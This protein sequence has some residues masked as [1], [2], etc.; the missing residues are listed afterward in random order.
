MW[1]P[2]W[3]VVAAVCLAPAVLANVGARAE[4]TPTNLAAAE[5]Q[6]ALSGD[7]EVVAVAGP[8]RSPWSVAVLP[9]GSILVTERPGGLQLVRPD[10][11]PQ[12]IA[13]VPQVLFEGH[14]GLLD[15]A[16]DPGFATNGTIYLS[17]VHGTARK[18][19]VRVARARLDL[20]RA[21]LG[22]RRVIFES[23]PAEEPELYGGARLA[24]TEDG[25]LFLSIGDRWKRHSAQDLSDHA[26]KI[27][28]IRTDGSVPG[29]N[30]FV[31]RP[32]AKPEIWSYGHRNQLGLAFDTR[33]G[34]LWSH[35][36]G[37]QGGDELNLIKPGANYG[38]PIISHG[39][40][41]DKAPPLEWKGPSTIEG[42]AKD[43][44]EQPVRYWVPSVAPS[45]LAVDYEGD[46]GVLWLGTLR[47]QS[48]LRLSIYDGR[49]VREERM[50]R[51]E[52]GRIRDVA[53]DPRGPLYVLQD[54]KEG[55]LYR[56]EPEVL[57]VR[58]DNGRQRL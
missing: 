9:D 17:Y 34:R 38:W 41:Y 12:P 18:S 45:G 54:A 37:P 20:E 31:S 44:M 15:V 27:V 30:P 47:G 35:E 57:R 25:H 51:D 21:R 10:H 33:T 50:L 24:L 56:V 36:N 7:L 39:Q 23:T 53:V 13:G 5:G 14:A 19:T 43:G 2:R 32:G 29:D 11:R 8:F 48:L 49:V 16:V 4:T 55:Y 40:E 42:T 46:R 58:R 52:I 26:G 3:A 22:E 28:R 6:P 1:L